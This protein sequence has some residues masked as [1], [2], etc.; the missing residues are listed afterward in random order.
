MPVRPMPLRMA[1]RLRPLPA[2]MLMLMVGLMDVQVLM[3]VR[4]MLVLQRLG[5]VLGPRPGR[6]EQGEDGDQT[7]HG[8]GDG[9]AEDRAEPAGSRVRDHPAGV[10]EGDPVRFACNKCGRAGR[11]RKFGLIERFKADMPLPELLVRISADCPRRRAFMG[12]DPCGAYYPDLAA[13]P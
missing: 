2:L 6:R 5:I 7:Q 11:S 13:S 10:R 4:P 12:N 3:V 8:E 1:V 9:Q